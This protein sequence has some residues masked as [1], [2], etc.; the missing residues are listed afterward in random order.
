LVKFGR[1]VFELRVRTD[2]QTDK[3]ANDILIQYASH[4]SRGRSSKT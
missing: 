3:Q 2:R 4:P 1:A